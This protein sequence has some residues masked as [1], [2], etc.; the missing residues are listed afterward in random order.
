MRRTLTAAILGFVAV[1]ATAFSAGGLGWRVNAGQSTPSVDPGGAS[2]LNVSVNEGTSMSVSVS[3]DGRTLAMDLQGSIWM[4]PV[5]GGTAK[6]I[7]DLFIDAHQPVWSPDGKRIVFFAYTEGGY[8]IWSMAP[9]GSDQ[10]KLTWGPFDER[11]PIWSHD[12]TRVA[13]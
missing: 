1:L 6:R 4:L 10:R 12:G 7:T 3:P 13:F 8:D 9:D 2:T 5:T 11:E